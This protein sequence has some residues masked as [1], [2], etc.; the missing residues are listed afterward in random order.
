MHPA[1]TYSGD[2]LGLFTDRAPGTRKWPKVVDSRLAKKGR[3]PISAPLCVKFQMLGKCVQ[4]CTLAHV[5]ANSMTVP[6]FN[7]A[8]RIMKEVTPQPTVT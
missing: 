7:Q 4:G 5:S 2:Y 8:D 3:P 6:E 1:W